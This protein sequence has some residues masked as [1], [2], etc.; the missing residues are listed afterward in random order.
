MNWGGS[1]LTTQRLACS[2]ADTACSALAAVLL[3]GTGSVTT[4]ATKP[5][6]TNIANEGHVAF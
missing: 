2:A 6:K 5:P 1:D 4:H 3:F